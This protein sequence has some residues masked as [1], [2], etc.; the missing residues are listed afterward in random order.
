MPKIA[1]DPRRAAL[2]QPEL[3]D[4]PLQGG[5]PADD[6]ALAVEAARL[7]YLRFDE[8]ADARER[9]AAT[10][11]LAGFGPPTLFEDAATDGQAYGALRADGLALLAFRGT[12]PDKAGDLVSDVEF[13]H[14]PWDLGDGVVHAGFRATA[15]GLWPGVQAWL[16]G[17]AQR[18]QR[19]IVC[20]HSLGA[21]IAT[22]LAAPAGADHLLTI[23]SPRVGDAVFIAALESTPGI[24]ITRIVHCCDVVTELPPA[25]LGFVHGGRLVYLDRDGNRHPDAAPAL[26]DSD[27]QQARLDYLA[28]YAFRAGTLLARDL[29]DHAPIN[30]VRAFWA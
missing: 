8:T 10:L 21:A 7:A 15:L 24:T 27:R 1:Y 17:P 16:A 12:Q 4:S 9:L 28:R 29:A 26:I 11:A 18:R 30:Y 20:G 25:G 3:G 14:R 2:Y 6:A 22:L 13:V 5:S 19:L 23:G